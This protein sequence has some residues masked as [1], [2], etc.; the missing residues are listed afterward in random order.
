MKQKFW[1]KLT[2]DKPY[3]W[4]DSLLAGTI[5]RLTSHS[6]WYT[7]PIAQGTQNTHF[8][9][10]PPSPTRAISQWARSL[11]WRHAVTMHTA[12]G[13]ICIT[14]FP[15]PCEACSLYLVL[16]FCERLANQSLFYFIYIFFFEACVCNIILDIA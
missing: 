16:W 8:S 14:F 3:G 4:E 10:S 5:L 12:V 7:Q 15:F 1:R 2:A 9:L 11:E 13:K 6:F